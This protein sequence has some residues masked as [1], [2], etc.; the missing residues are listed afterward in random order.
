[1]MLPPVKIANCRSKTAAAHRKPNYSIG[2]RFAAAVGRTLETD[3]VFAAEFSESVSGLFLH[4]TPYQT[5]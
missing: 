5:G 3:K 2:S 4:M 1:M